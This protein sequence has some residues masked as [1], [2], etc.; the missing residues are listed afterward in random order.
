VAFVISPS[1]YNMPIDL[2]LGVLFPLHAHVGINAIVTDYVPK[3]IQSSARF[4]LA[5]ATSIAI[6]GLLKLNV[7]GVGMTETIKSLWRKKKL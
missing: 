5:G 6:L 3:A 1:K 4:G 2:S 7:F